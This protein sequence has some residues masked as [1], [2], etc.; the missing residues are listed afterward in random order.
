MTGQLEQQS[1]VINI[2]SSSE[3]HLVLFKLGGEEFGVDINDVR[4]IIKFESITRIP[5]TANYILGAI[6]LRGA[7]ITVID[8]SM[9]LGLEPKATDKNTR[10]IVMEIGANTVGMVV[11]S[12]TEVLRLKAEQVQ[13]T[14][15]IIGSKFQSSVNANYMNGIGTLK[16]RMIILLDLKKIVDLKELE[17]AQR[18][19]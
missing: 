4:E 6:N 3:K 17:Q 1:A 10:I 5:N 13:P 11:D 15:S 19:R 16:D 7:I 2:K 9:K 18:T 12:A 14:P 8:L